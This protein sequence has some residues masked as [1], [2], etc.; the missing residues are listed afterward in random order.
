M[1]NP[2]NLNHFQGST[3]LLMRNELLKKR[4]M[5][6]FEGKEE[7]TRDIFF[8]FPQDKKIKESSGTAMNLIIIKIITH[9]TSDDPPGKW[10][11]AQGGRKAK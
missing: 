10:W 4:R 1:S 7:I 2:I 6:I 5:Q 11:R 8:C 3:H 9:Q